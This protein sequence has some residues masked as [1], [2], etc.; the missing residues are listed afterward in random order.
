MNRSVSGSVGIKKLFG[1]IEVEY[2]TDKGL[3]A[4]FNKKLTDGLVNIEIDTNGQIKIMSE[5]G[6]QIGSTI[7]GKNS[8]LDGQIDASVGSIQLAVKGVDPDTIS[9]E[10]KVGVKIGIFSGAYGQVH[11]FDVSNMP[12]FRIRDFSFSGTPTFNQICSQYPKHTLPTSC[13]G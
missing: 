13:G 4:K 12:L 2:S 7:D 8:G 9:V 1:A 6:V 5:E 11:H 10:W 3:Q